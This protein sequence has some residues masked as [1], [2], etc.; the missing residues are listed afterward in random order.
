MNNMKKF[1]R[2]DAINCTDNQLLHIP[3]G[4]TFLDVDFAY[5]VVRADLP[6]VQTL[7]IPSTVT[8]IA[9]MSGD[10]SCGPYGY[11]DNPF[12]EILVDE[13]NEK[14]SSVDGILFSKDGKELICYPCGRKNK[15]YHIPEGV[16]IIREEAFL[17]VEHLE[18]VY[19]P[20]SLEEIEEGAFKACA[21]LEETDEIRAFPGAYMEDWV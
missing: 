21:K 3:E 11:K 10:C 13:R 19:L 4:Y 14:F 9:T 6:R 5:F 20:R 16:E 8:H 1:T 7:I 2:K 18:H 12:S 17:N 15:E